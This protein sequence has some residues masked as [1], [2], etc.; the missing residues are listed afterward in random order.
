MNNFKKIFLLAAYIAVLVLIS[1]QC[2]RKPT[3]VEG[4]D[5][6]YLNVN[7]EI[8]EINNLPRF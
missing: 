3:V 7:E 5:G 4:W 2:S 1:Y 6:Q 8:A